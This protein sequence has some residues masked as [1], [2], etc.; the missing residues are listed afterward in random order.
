MF[1]DQLWS[2]LGSKCSGL[3]GRAPRR[4]C[5]TQVLDSWRWEQQTFQKYMELEQQAAQ[6]TTAAGL[7]N[8][9]WH[10]AK[11]AHSE[12][13]HSGESA[14]YAVVFRGCTKQAGYSAGFRR[15]AVQYDS[16]AAP[17]IAEGGVVSYDPAAAQPQSVALSTSASV[18]YDVIVQ[19]DHVYYVWMLAK[20]DADTATGKDGFTIWDGSD[21]EHTWAGLR[22]A[23]GLQWLKAP[24]AL[25]FGQRKQ[26]SLRLAPL[27]GKCSISQLYVGSAETHVDVSDSPEFVQPGGGSK[28]KEA[29][30]KALLGEVRH[31]KLKQQ[32]AASRLGEAAHSEDP[33]S[34][35]Q[36]TLEKA[37]VATERVD[38]LQAGMAT[39]L[40]DLY[41]RKQ[42]S[43]T[44]EQ[45]QAAEAALV[46]MRAKMLQVVA[47]QRTQKHAVQQ[48]EH[49]DK[50]YRASKKIGE[51]KEQLEVLMPLIRTKLPD[52]AMAIGNLQGLQR[53]NKMK[54]LQR[55]MEKKVNRIESEWRLL[56]K[57]AKQRLADFKAF[58]SNATQLDNSPHDNPSNELQQ[59]E[60]EIGKKADQDAQQAVAANQ[61]SQDGDAEMMAALAAQH[62]ANLASS[63]GLSSGFFGGSESPCDRLAHQELRGSCTALYHEMSDTCKAVFGTGFSACCLSEI[64]QWKWQQGLWLKLRSTKSKLE[65]LQ[66]SLA[67]DPL[68]E[69]IAAI[70]RETAATKLSLEH[71]W[72]DSDQNTIVLAVLG[73]CRVADSGVEAVLTRVNDFVNRTRSEPASVQNATGA[74]PAVDK[75]PEFDASDAKAD[76]A[77]VVKEFTAGLE[78]TLLTRH[79]VHE[80]EH[81]IEVNAV[82]GEK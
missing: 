56:P 64:K 45:R 61:A 8:K 11:Q 20:C 80:A 40:S 34:Q 63:A 77:A 3:Q 46:A 50:E 33:E 7:S 79:S 19:K 76:V 29:T 54:V 22:E 26:F 23:S 57:E 81:D 4:V 27:G 52:E 1:I 2:R 49:A 10:A 66:A 55:D 37:R 42:A 5:C 67:E 36:R 12:W 39:A 59:V 71:E 75:E 14:A 17:M 68:Q 18:E 9:L 51:L 38:E 69:D 31:S 28:R 43:I 72:A 35:L 65:Q 70:E 6:N 73:V 82:S 78:D 25:E 16:I 13:D 21:I 47:H 24:L 53:L 62:K 60:E 44:N 32:H 58:S 48:L 41:E 15:N 74:P 30:T